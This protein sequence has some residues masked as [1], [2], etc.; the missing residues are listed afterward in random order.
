MEKSKVVYPS[1]RRTKVKP[2]TNNVM[3]FCGLHVPLTNLSCCGA[4][5]VPTVENS[6]FRSMR[7]LGRTLV[8]LIVTCPTCGDYVRILCV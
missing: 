2:E 1:P 6:S 8:T 3:D 4:K 7:C 5:L